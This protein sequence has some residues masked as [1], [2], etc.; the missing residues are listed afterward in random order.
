MMT[1]RRVAVIAALV[2]VLGAVA[3]WL[4]PVDEAYV[5]RKRLNGFADEINKTTT[6]G[7]GMVA[8]AAQLSMYLTEDVEVD[9]GQGA[10]PIRG[11]AT[12][13]G[14]AERLQP[15]T[16]AFR[17]RFEDVT[18]SVDPGG[19]TATVHLTAEFIRRSFTTGEESLDAREFSLSMRRVGG[20]WQI[21][22]VTAIQV[23]K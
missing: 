1:T 13:V 11:R 20:D 8:R 9:L 17:L 10:M 3:W 6:D 4:W 12:L 2:A 18:V 5:V 23:L 16:A 22:T 19:Q 7:I 21:A 14:M 15:R